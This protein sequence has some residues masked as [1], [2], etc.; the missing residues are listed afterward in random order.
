MDATPSPSSNRPDPVRVVVADDHAS[1][2]Y[3]LGAV[4]S[5]HRRLE[6][7]GQAADGR[8]A[9]DLILESRP[10]VALIDVMMAPMDGFGVCRSLRESASPSWTSVIL[11]SAFEDPELAARGRLCGAAGYLSKDVSNDAL[12]RAVLEVARGGTAFD[13]PRM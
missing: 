2:R 13:P 4:L 8:R 6:V 3:A 10:H 1:Y 7:V 9:V 12:C 5:A 11:I